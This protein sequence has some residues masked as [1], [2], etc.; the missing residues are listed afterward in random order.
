MHDLHPHSSPGR[1]GNFFGAGGLARHHVLMTFNQAQRPRGR[2]RRHASHRQ[3]QVGHRPGCS[4][5]P[6]HLPHPA[7]RFRRAN[8]P[9]R[10]SSPAGGPSPARLLPL[11]KRSVRKCQRELPTEIKEDG[12][13][14]GRL[15]RMLGQ[16]RLG[17]EGLLERPWALMLPPDVP[18]LNQGA[19]S[20]PGELPPATGILDLPEEAH[21]LVAERLDLGDR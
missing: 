18:R 15:L 7:M 11:E 20:Q 17:H 10:S 6:P 2:G 8:A 1:Q 9:S 21:L 4:P 12:E 19:M 16:V 14:C 5:G 3:P 13:E